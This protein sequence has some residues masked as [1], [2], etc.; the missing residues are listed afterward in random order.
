[1]GLSQRPEMTMKKTC[2][3]CVPHLGILVVL[4]TKEPARVKV[5]AVSSI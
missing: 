5:P 2:V 4:L 3:Q 1:M